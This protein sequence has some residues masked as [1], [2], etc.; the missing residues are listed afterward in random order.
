MSILDLV[1]YSARERRMART[2][3]TWF[4]AAGYPRA[5]AKRLARELLAKCV[6]EADEQGLRNVWNLGERVCADADFTVKRLAV[7]LAIEDIRDAWNAGFVW[8][9]LHEE[10][11]NVTNLPLYRMMV[12]EQG[13]PSKEAVWTMRRILPYFGDPETSHADFQGEDAD[14]YF[15]F[16]TRFDRWRD[17]LQP[18]AAPKLAERFTSTRWFANTF[19]R[20]R[21]EAWYMPLNFST[22][23]AVG[24]RFEKVLVQ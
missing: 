6:A 11:S 17:Q 10:A 9:R 7:G 22:L 14:L 16:R 23:C 3:C 19:E 8:V 24:F 5:N 20:A 21:F 1:R 12:E 13:L 15:E 18:G 2:I 4:V